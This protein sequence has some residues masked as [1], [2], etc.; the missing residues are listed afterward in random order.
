MVSNTSD[1]QEMWNKEGTY[2][3]YSKIR[4]C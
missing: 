3:A 4:C 2:S 1:A